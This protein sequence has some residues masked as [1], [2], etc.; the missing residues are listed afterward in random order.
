MIWDWVAWVGG[1]SKKLRVGT[2]GEF[3]GS[4]GQVQARFQIMVGVRMKEELRWGFKSAMVS[5]KVR[6][7]SVLTMRRKDGLPYGHL[8]ES[9]GL[10]RG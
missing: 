7:G 6:G 5:D 4:A 3:R 9:G 2:E 10:A 8:D 1:G